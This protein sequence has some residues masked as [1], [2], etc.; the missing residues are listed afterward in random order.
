MKNTLTIPARRPYN[1]I[2]VQVAIGLSGTLISLMLGTIFHV[3]YG[4]P[5]KP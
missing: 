2:V 1:N 5:E 4:K 3:R